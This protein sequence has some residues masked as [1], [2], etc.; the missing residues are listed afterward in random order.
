MAPTSTKVVR[1]GKTADTAAMSVTADHWPHIA[2]GATARLGQRPD[3]MTAAG[4]KPEH[5]S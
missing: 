1:L 2:Y 3:A 5:A 4:S